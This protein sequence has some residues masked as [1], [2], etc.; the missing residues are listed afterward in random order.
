MFRR[1]TEVLQGQ[2]AS[3]FHSYQSQSEDR[4]PGCSRTYRPPECDLLKLRISVKYDIWTL[5]C[6]LLDFLTWYLLGWT[7]VNK[8]FPDARLIDEGWVPFNSD[9]TSAKSAHGSYFEDEFYI[10]KVDSTHMKRAH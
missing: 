10:L 7:A 2:P 4:L 9:S 8:V 3:R 1:H 6:L 5:G